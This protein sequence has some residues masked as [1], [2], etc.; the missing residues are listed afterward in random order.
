[1]SSDVVLEGSVERSVLSPGVVVERGAC[2]RDSVIMHRCKVESGAVVDRAILDKNVRVGKGAC[3]GIGDVAPN[4]LYPQTLSSGVTV[5]GKGCVIPEG[6][7]VGRSCI[8]GPNMRER[9]FRHAEIPSGNVVT[10]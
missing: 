8:V 3:V 7:R 5:V 9:D 4:Q 10:P 1:V 6:L 2:V